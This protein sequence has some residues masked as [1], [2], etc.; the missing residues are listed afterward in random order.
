MLGRKAAADM[1]NDATSKRVSGWLV[2]VL[3]LIAGPGAARAETMAV[4]VRGQGPGADKAAAFVEHFVL[5][6]MD[7]D[8]RYELIDVTRELGDPSRKRSKRAFEKADSLIEKGRQAYESLDLGAT[9]RHINQ[10]LKIY[11]RQAAYLDHPKDVADAMMLLGATHILMG[12]QRTGRKR[13]GQAYTLFPEV[14][15]DPRVFNPTMRNAFSSVVESLES[16]PGGRLAVTS[17]PSYVRIY[18]NGE[19]RGVAPTSVKELLEGPHFVRFEKDGYRP[20]GKYLGITAGRKA[21]ENG[22]LKPAQRYNKYAGHVD[23]IMEAVADTDPD[24]DYVPGSVLDLGEMLGARHVFVV[25]V[26]LDGEQVMLNANQFDLEQERRL[27]NAAETFSYDTNVQTYARVVDTLLEEHFNEDNLNEA[28]SATE[29]TL[30]HSAGA[31]CFGYSCS[32]VKKVLLYGGGGLGVV[33]A[34]IGGTLWGT[35]TSTYNQWLTVPQVSDESTQ[36]RKRGGAQAVI[37]DVFVPMGLAIA[38]ASVAAYFLW[39]PTGSPE[40]TLE[41]DGATTLSG[42]VVPLGDGGAGVFVNVDY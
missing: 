16:K 22:S 1:S 35:A 32:L 17:N 21:S 42:G 6:A 33:M 7:A 14:E 30:G 31:Q 38:G 9:V 5:D 36:L 12:Q 25:A 10:A 11:R 29:V 20:W 39:E 23:S 28:T 37:G 26:Q 3:G 40:S 13:L 27:K 8:D 18:V 41:E 24:D 2:V 4:V 34:G 19:F 15:P